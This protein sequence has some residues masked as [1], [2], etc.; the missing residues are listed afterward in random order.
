MVGVRQ[1]EGSIVDVPV[2]GIDNIVSTQNYC[3]DNQIPKFYVLNY[4]NNQRWKVKK[5]NS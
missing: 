2:M 3:E 4:E 5:I 1:I